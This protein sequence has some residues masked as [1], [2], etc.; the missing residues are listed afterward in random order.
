MTTATLTK[1]NRVIFTCKNK[2]CKQVWAFEY[3]N[4]NNGLSAGS[5][6]YRIENGKKVFYGED[7]NGRCPNCR[8]LHIEGNRV[9]GKVTDHVC[10]AKCMSAKNGACECSC[11]GAN[12]G[13]SHL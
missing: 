9:E 10:N 1:T 6:L 8:S 3:E 7:I 13:I 11:G 5:S 2:N 4:A 12:H